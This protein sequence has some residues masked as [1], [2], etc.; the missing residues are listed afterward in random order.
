M[1]KEKKVES[2][3]SSFG[4]FSLLKGPEF[5]PKTPDNGDDSSITDDVEDKDPALIEETDEEAARLKA[6]SDALIEADRQREL[7][8][9]SKAASKE[10][11]TEEDD[12]D[13]EDVEGK[14]TPEAAGLIEFTKDL[15]DKGVL[16]FDDTD[17][18]FD[19]T[20]DGLAKLVD[21]TTQN[22]ITKWA[23]TL[24]SDFKK[25]LNYTQNGGKTQD[26]LNVYYGNQSWETFKPESEETQKAAVI[27]SLRLAGETEE[28]IIDMVTEFTDNGTLEKRAKSALVKLQKHEAFEKE[29]ILKVQ[30][31][32][33]AKKLKEDKEYWD[34]FNKDLMSKED[35]KGF[36][37]SKKEK[38]SLWDFMSTTNKSGKTPYQEALENDKDAALLF[39]YFTMKKFD[40]NKLEKQVE[41]KVSGKFGDMLSNYSKTSKQKISGG[42][43]EHPQENNTFAGF[44][45]L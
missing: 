5:N 35:I 27:A 9:K 13:N 34:N 1:S 31:A 19:K 28:D 33:K 21:K 22:R 18:D 30:E 43:T 29:N 39:A 26:F 20:P 3:E 36:K 42:R 38:D 32:E 25:L 17:E 12:E 41:T 23:D 11:T 37:V 24:D 4:K 14:L 44:K 2:N 8:A 15:F 7:L 10:P 6:E 40:I 16:D 45:T